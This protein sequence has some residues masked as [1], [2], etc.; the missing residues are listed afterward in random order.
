RQVFA[1]HD[2]HL[3][4]PPGQ[5]RLGAGGRLNHGGGHPRP[6]YQTLCQARNSTILPRAMATLE[7]EHTFNCSQAT[8]WDE[9]FMDNEDNERLFKG[10]LKFPVWRELKRE[11][12]AGNLYRVL[13]VVPYV[14]ELPAA[15]KAV[16]GEGV[17]YEERGILDRASMR[18]KVEVVPNR[19][20][21]KISIK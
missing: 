14:G 12:R 20:A 4:T 5:R 2:Q 13:E 15:L 3:A 18:Y 8:F 19:M 16:V 11:E 17:G 21:E 10:E 6:S 1:V 7:V 9:I